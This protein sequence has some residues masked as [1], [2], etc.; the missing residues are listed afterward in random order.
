M[1]PK[2]ISAAFHEG[3]WRET[4]DAMFEA[5][6]LVVSVMD[7]SIS[8]VMHS[9]ARC[10]YCELALPPSDRELDPCFDEPPQM[11]AEGIT[12]TTCR[13]G[14]PCFIATVDLE[15][16]TECAV[17]VGGFVSSTR[18]RKLLFEK[19]LGRGLAEN[20]ARVAVREIPILPHHQ[21]EALVRV[22]RSNAAA[23]LNNIPGEQDVPPAGR[24]F[25][26][27]AGAGSAFIERREAGQDLFD[28]ILARALDIVDAESGLVMLTRRGTE[29]LEAV[30]PRVLALGGRHVLRF[31][32]G[33]AGRAA[34]SE[35]G[36]VAQ[37]DSPDLEPLCA[38]F[39]RGIAT[40]AAVPMRFENRTIGVLV[41]NLEHAGRMFSEDDLG[42]LEQYAAIAAHTVDNAF[43]HGAAQR[44]MFE[45]RRLGDL[46]KALSAT[47]DIGDVSRKSAMALDDC[48]GFRVGGMVVTGWGLDSAV[49]A[50]IGEVS[51]ADIDIVTG[52]AT[53]RDVAKQP[54]DSLRI[55]THIGSVVP[56]GGHSG[57]WSILSSE[58]LSHGS[59]IGYVFVSSPEPGA[60]GA[61]DH[62][63]LEGLAEHIS[64]AL[65]RSA[66]LHRVREDLTKTITA[67]SVTVDVTAHATIGH[68]GRVTDYAMSL[69][70]E[71]GL[72]VEHVELLRFA[73]LLHDIGKTGVSEEILLKPS[74]LTDDEIA[75][76]RK[77]VEIGAGIV[78]QIEF[79]NAL[80]P[81]IM[82][83]HECWD[84]SGYPAGL[85]GEDIPLLSRILAIADSFDAMT[86][87]TPHHK[88]L[89][90]SQAR[91]E[92]KAAAGSQLD[93][94]LVGAFVAVMDRRALA[95]GMGL[96][97]PQTSDESQL[98][99]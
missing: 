10:S 37:E 50:A 23:V 46:A 44:A 57:N 66:T 85:A 99:S 74:R 4:V 19:L 63:L 30:A 79:L 36:L 28:T 97:S 60:F 52:E 17:V 82:H 12:R 33:L 5:T 14:L 95:G 93:P 65:E 6:G 90:Y 9:G 54:F 59:V 22:L 73:G 27:V 7:P 68:S 25:E 72:D 18:E 43:V 87:D 67:L 13:A 15:G 48:F 55:L 35:H 75:Q 98:P 56:D 86:S 83:H 8:S 88:R 45:L 16:A 69:G 71:I 80:K 89:T 91:L 94:R 64:A 24:E 32:E 41:V 38:L 61:A 2:T 11:A 81:V 49:V 76:V 34:I 42:K 40:S 20:Q 96:M 26:A 58:L 84:G 1:D 47:S 31:G 51:H 21:V 3:G 39:G 70:Q 62:R 29:F 92:M 53:G 78:E 77:H